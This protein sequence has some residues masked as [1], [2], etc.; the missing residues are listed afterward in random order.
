MIQIKSQIQKLIISFRNLVEKILEFRSLSAGDF[1]WIRN[2]I[3]LFCQWISPILLESDDSDSELSPEV[4]ED[5]SRRIFN[6][7]A[8]KAI[9]AIADQGKNPELMAS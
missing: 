2:A 8:G 3:E 7:I 6:R 9:Q 5:E 1:E 4:R